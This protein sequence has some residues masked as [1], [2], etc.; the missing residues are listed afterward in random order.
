MLSIKILFIYFKFNNIECQVGLPNIY[1]TLKDINRE[2]YF[3][4]T[5]RE[6]GGSFQGRVCEWQIYITKIML[7]TKTK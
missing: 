7:L 1:Y 5:Q 3:C 2:S 6:E 4:Q